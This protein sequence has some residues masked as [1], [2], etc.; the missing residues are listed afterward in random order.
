MKLTL[1]LIL[2]ALLAF[3]VPFFVYENIEDYYATFGFRGNDLFTRPW[4][5]VT[6]VFLHGNIE[7]LLSNVLVWFFF[8]IAVEA[9]LG[10]MKTAAMFFIG[11][12]A[13]NLLSMLFYSPD[14]VFIGASAGIF[15]LI[16]IGMMVK[17]LDVS[18]YPLIIP[19]PL[20][21][22][23]MGY[24]LF[25]ILAL[26][27]GESSNISYIGHLAGLSIG[28]LYGIMK[29]GLKRGALIVFLTLLIMIAIPLI[30]LFLS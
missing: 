24:V 16:G 30:V 11:A 14:T 18:F 26:F 1:I 13:G 12:V 4:T 9:E 5:L 3:F 23:G 21:L 19:I 6:S 17:P 22:L 7:H 2:M 15:T 29:V 27:S 20:A 10:K 28:F 8:G 25:N